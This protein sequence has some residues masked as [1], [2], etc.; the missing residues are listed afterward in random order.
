MQYLKKFQEVVDNPFQYARNWKD[1]TGRN[2]LATFCSYVPEEIVLAA[3]CLPFRIFG[4]G[5][6]LEKV[7]AYLQ[8]YSCSLVRGALEDAMSG[9]LDFVDGAVFPHTCDSIQRLSD[10]WRMNVGFDLHLDI[11]L[12][13]KLNT[14]SA[15][16]YMIDTVRKFQRELA[17]ALA[18][19]ISR[20]K[21]VEATALMN[22]VREGLENLYQIRSRN[23]E[24]I[25]GSELHTIVK[26]SMLMDKEEFLAILDNVT[27]KLDD[28]ESAS[29][30][31]RRILL[32]G[33][34]CSMPDIYDIVRQ[35]G[36][37]VIWDDFCTGS[38]YFSKAVEIEDDMTASIAG[39]YMDRHI[40]P[41]KH[42]GIDGRG[43]EI[44][45]MAKEK[46]AEGVIFVL[47]KF[48]DPHAFDYPYIRDMLKE[49]GIPSMLYEIEEQTFTEGQF[50]TRCE[51]FI[52]LL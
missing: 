2:V 20:E 44:V 35:A 50:Q 18:V 5:S 49:A 42:N 36:A 16:A 40:C 39:R 41:A 14:D 37:D 45:R 4:S 28:G 33:G 38:R 15:R 30:N 6:E 27:S 11:V 29:V 32:A 31:A 13:V 34:L 46:N 23:P 17:A 51:A 48:C 8:A 1:R 26:A 10:L 19:E 21:L 25:S 12:P 52:E 3:G 47:L 24:Q 43:A 7:D 9:R 22:R